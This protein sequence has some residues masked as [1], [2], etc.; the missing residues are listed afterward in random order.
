MVGVLKKA[1]SQALVCYYPFA[2][3]FVHNTV[4]EPQLLCNNRG[5]DFIEAFAHVELQGL[6]FYNPDYSIEG[7]LVPKKKQGVLSVQPL[8]LSTSVESSNTFFSL[9]LLL[10][11]SSIKDE[12]IITAIDHNRSFPHHCHRSQPK[13]SYL[14]VLAVVCRSASL[15]LGA[16]F[17]T[18]KD[19]I[20]I[21]AIDHNRSF[22]HHCHRSQPKLSYLVVLAVVCRSASHQRCSLRM[23]KEDETSRVSR[24]V[25][26]ALPPS[27]LNRP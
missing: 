24:P 9:F 26:S 5:V 19:E 2:G 10:S 6:N 22:P 16:Q 17:L 3:E 4:G 23:T 20:I 13:L 27:P 8:S 7:K 1:M 21:T 11:S 12:I 15:F 18:L 25:G 14:V